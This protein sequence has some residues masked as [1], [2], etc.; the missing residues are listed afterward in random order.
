MKRRKVPRYV[1]GK[2]GDRLFNL[3]A[4]FIAR[5]LHEDIEWI[6]GYVK[7]GDYYP[8]GNYV[9]DKDYQPKVVL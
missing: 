8:E 1:K 4:V 2:D 9:K 7:D 6:D 3:V 5:T